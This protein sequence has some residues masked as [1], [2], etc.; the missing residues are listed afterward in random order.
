MS[1]N[2]GV[3]SMAEK[4]I[5]EKQLEEYEDVFADIV[6]VL[7][8]DGEQIIKPEELSSAPTFSAYHDDKNKKLRELERDT[9]KYWNVAN[10]HIA[11]IGLEN[12]TSVYK[13]M[14]IRIIGYDGT[15]YRN[16]LNKVEDEKKE[17][18]KG[19]IFPVVT[20]VLYFGYKKHWKRPLTL[21]ECFDIPPKLEPYVN[22]Y[23]M[24]LYEI[25][26]LEEETISKFQSDFKFVAEYFSQ[27]RKTGEWKPMPQKVRHIRELM[28][29]FAALTEDEKFLDLVEILE[30]DGT[31]RP[32][33]GLDV[34]ENRGFE[35]G[36][37]QGE[38]RG[39]I[40]GIKEKTISVVTNM[41]KKNYSY[42]T[43]AELTET[44]LDDVARIAKEN[45]L[46]HS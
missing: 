23:K 29:L 40:A 33:S 43:I 37:S 34:I 4:D 35:R 21:K 16:T 10:I 19:D 13:Y 25:A 28:D 38:S 44:A 15:I 5:S 42:E 30:G 32:L 41:L 31:M 27:M 22:D 2:F 26:W 12:Q 3:M 20:L 46:I 1:K 14:P 6:N 11:Y 36:M 8:F 17:I 45:G 9:A 7:L 39:R 18:V 24:N